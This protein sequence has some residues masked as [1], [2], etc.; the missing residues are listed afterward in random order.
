MR[1]AVRLTPRAGRNA[2]DGWHGDV[3]LARVSAP[4]AHHAANDALIRLLAK[5]LHIPST[6]IAIESGT[7]S[8]TKLIEIDGLTI[9]ELHHR[10]P[11]RTDD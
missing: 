1:L 7:H 5:S 10:L 4:P 3:L 8:R 11:R 2:I 6:A 9:D